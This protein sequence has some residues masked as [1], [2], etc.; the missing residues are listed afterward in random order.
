[1]VKPTIFGVSTESSAVSTDDTQS[2]SDVIASNVGIVAAI[3][4][5]VK[6][7][8]IPSLKVVPSVE[9]LQVSPSFKPLIVI[10]L[11]LVMLSFFDKVLPLSLE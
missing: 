3:V 10:V 4:V 8:S 6:L 5:A 1:V 7:L 2:F 11:S 9:Y